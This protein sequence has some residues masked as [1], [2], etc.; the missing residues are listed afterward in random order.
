MVFFTLFAALAFF[1]T[2]RMFTVGANGFHVRP[3][4]D[5]SDVVPLSILSAAF[6]VL[7]IGLGV[8]ILGKLRSRRSGV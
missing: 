5:G 8:Q 3:G 2:M 7:A 1:Q 6:G 4:V